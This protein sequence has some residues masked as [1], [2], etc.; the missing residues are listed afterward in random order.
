MDPTDNCL[1]PDKVER[2][3]VNIFDFVKAS[4]KHAFIVQAWR[5]CSDVKSKKKK[6][7]NQNGGLLFDQGDDRGQALSIQE[8]KEIFKTTHHVLQ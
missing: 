7:R 4:S 1:L 5:G 3:K 8:P 2:T 6:Q